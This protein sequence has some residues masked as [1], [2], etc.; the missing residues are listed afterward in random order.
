M[1]QKQDTGADLLIDYLA[2]ESTPEQTAMVEQWLAASAEN[3]IELADIKGTWEQVSGRPVDRQTTEVLIN[4]SQTLAA[5]V[6]NSD[7][8]RSRLPRWTAY[9]AAA[10]AV[11]GVLIYSQL[12]PP[13]QT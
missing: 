5:H 13:S 3:R 7:K 4:M 8:P 12:V 1:T 9:A 6:S 2:G 11:A 10:A